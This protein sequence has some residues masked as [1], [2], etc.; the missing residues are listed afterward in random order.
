MKN[1]KDSKKEQVR[2]IYSNI[3]TAWAN[4]RKKAG[5]KLLGYLIFF[6]V[7]FLFAAITSNINEYKTTI[8]KTSTTTTTSPDKYIDKQK[9]LLTNKYN[10]NYII[11]INSVEYKI[12]GTIDN[13]I[14]NGYFETPDGIKKIVFKDSILYEINNQE[15]VLLES[16]LNNNLIDINYI[17]NL[18]KQNSAIISDNEETKTYT[19]NINNLNI[20]VTTNEESILKINITDLT[21]IYILNFDN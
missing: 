5:I 13:N 16:E 9:S 7:L 12:N 3:K 6:I 11:N 20:V 2:E 18:I 1:K 19:Y 10:I 8:N 14:V 21:N 15:E 17:I 4:P